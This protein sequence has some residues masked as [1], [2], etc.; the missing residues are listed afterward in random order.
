MVRRR[1]ARGDTATEAVAAA[2]RLPTVDADPA[3]TTGRRR[4]GSRRPVRYYVLDA[5][6]ISDG[7]STALLPELEGLKA[8]TP[9]C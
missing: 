4:S 6:T 7:S 2:E 5:P 1:P 3:A 9:H 8:S